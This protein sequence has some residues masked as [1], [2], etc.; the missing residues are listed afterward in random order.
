[1]EVWVVFPNL[2]ELATKLPY[3]AIN[4]AGQDEGRLAWQ[5]SHTQDAQPW[6]RV[7]LCF[8]LSR[9]QH[10]GEVK[11]RPFWTSN[12]LKQWREAK[13]L[14]WQVGIESLRILTI[15]NWSSDLIQNLVWWDLMVTQ[16][17]ISTLHARIC[18]PQFGSLEIPAWW[19]ASHIWHILRVSGVH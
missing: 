11:H 13:Q 17:Q 10:E 9:E 3:E 8:L 1:M 6:P 18:W 4:A 7:T 5:R 14:S 2:T 12:T 19:R 16:P 15:N